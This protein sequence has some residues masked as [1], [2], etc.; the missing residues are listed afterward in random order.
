MKNIDDPALDRNIH[1]PDLFTS[2]LPIA[3][4]LARCGAEPMRIFSVLT[5][6]AFTERSTYMQIRS[7]LGRSHAVAF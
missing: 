2:L 3:Q 6:T 7:S 5:E 1:S 4:V